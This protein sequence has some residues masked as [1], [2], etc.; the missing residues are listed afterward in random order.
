MQSTVCC[1]LAL[2]NENFNCL[3]KGGRHFDSFLKLSRQI[4][5]GTL[6]LTQYQ[7]CMKDLGNYLIFFSYKANSAQLLN[8]KK[9]C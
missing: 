9:N 4:I 8:L 5:G 2:G 7:T 1:K 6:I 3:I